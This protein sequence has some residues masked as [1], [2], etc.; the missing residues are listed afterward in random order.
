KPPADLLALRTL[1]WA[2]DASECR[3]IVLHPGAPSAY[4]TPASIRLLEHT[5]LTEPQ[6]LVGGERIRLDLT[7]DTHFRNGVPDILPGDPPG[8][9]DAPGNA[10][11]NENPVKTYHFDGVIPLPGENPGQLG[12]DVIDAVR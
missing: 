11:P 8:N 9:P 1:Q 10:P 12:G 3:R 2:S 6:Q 4:T 5:E 7:I